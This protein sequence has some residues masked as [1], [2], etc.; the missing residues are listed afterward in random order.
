M[1]HTFLRH[2]WYV[3]AWPEEIARA[4][5]RRVFLE[6][7][8]LLYRREDGAPVALA[9]ACP[10][11]MVPLSRGQLVGD[12]IECCYHGLRF[13]SSGACTLN[14][15]GDG[16]IPRAARVRAYPLIERH[17][18]TWIWLGDAPADPAE[19]PD[20]SILNAPGRANVHG[21]LHVEANYQL[22]TDNLLD[23]SHVQFLHPGLRVAR[24]KQHRH[25][26]RQD[27]DKVSSFFWRDEGLPNALMQMCGWPAQQPGDTRAHMHWH[28]P[29]LMLLDVGITG[30]GRPVEE[31][32]AVPSVH[33]LTPETATTT[34]YF[35]GFVRQVGLDDMALGERI[36]ALGIQA[37]AHEDK[38]VIEAQQK[39]VG[40]ADIMSMGLALLQPDAS[41]V[42][43]R[44]VL[45]SLLQAEMNGSAR[46]AAGAGD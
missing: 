6:T 15:H 27:G 7:P 28:K 22:I 36:R 42:R 38:P 41:A 34:H 45:A 2:C 32:V 3:A 37:F 13:D 39:A 17:G 46:A 5:L 8:V 20:F 40:D 11:R 14:P 29:S 4:P 21:T 26:M 9:D 44:R 12:E 24:A 30:V 25:E 10:H 31:G 23:L 43:A 19:I 33:L 35:F 16:S 1:G 18:L